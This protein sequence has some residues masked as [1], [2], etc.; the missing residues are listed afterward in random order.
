MLTS[1]HVLTS[2]KFRIRYYR[3]GLPVVEIS[4]IHS[5]NSAQTLL[6]QIAYCFRHQNGCGS[7]KEDGRDSICYEVHVRD[8][9]V[10]ARDI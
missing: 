3:R 1:E 6:C 7:V 10:T 8:G 5:L 9:R 2:G 4:G